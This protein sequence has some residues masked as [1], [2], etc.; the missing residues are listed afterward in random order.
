MHD[1]NSAVYQAIRRDYRSRQLDLARALERQGQLSAQL[2]QVNDDI[3]KARTAI[4][5]L[6]SFAVANRWSRKWD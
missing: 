2:A 4:A 5:E 3:V 1:K 6:D